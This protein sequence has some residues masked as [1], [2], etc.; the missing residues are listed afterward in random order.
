MY[1][2][3]E[4]NLANQKKNLSLKKYIKTE[5]RERDDIKWPLSLANVVLL[6]WIRNLH[7]QKQL[8]ISI[9]TTAVACNY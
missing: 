9:S 7:K 2:L 5:E 1:F 8:S 4:K 3:L 6:G